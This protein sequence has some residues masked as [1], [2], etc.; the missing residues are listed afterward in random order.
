MIRKGLGMCWFG[1]R[2]ETVRV[3]GFFTGEIV[4]EYQ[5]QSEEGVFGILERIR[6]EQREWVDI[7]AQER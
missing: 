5:S 3:R 1:V 7:P 4:A 2:E 6:E